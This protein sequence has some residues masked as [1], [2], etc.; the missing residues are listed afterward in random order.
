MVVLNWNVMDSN[1]TVM[2]EVDTTN[3]P[4]DEEVRDVTDFV[5][6]VLFG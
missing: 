1:V 6:D 2:D 5:T 4:L 3:S